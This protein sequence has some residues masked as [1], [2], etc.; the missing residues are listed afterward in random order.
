M[1]EKNYFT[2]I[3]QIST[4][5]FYI[6]NSQLIINDIR[7]TLKGKTMSRMFQFL[8]YKTLK[9]VS[10]L[11]TFFL[12]KLDEL[13]LKLSNHLFKERQLGFKC[14]KETISQYLDQAERLTMTEPNSTSFLKALILS[15]FDG[16]LQIKENIDKENI[17]MQ[18][19]ES[20]QGNFEIAHHSNFFVFWA[21]QLL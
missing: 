19:C 9:I 2:K 10:N 8:I 20:I 7:Q 1:L 15:I 21:H 12:Y 3:S 5:I 11:C 14:I 17:M 6:F 16:L 4:F 18:Y 13:F